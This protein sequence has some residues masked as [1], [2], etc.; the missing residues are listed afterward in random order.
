MVRGVGWL[1][2]CVG[3]LVW[4]VCLGWLVGWLVGSRVEGL[5]VGG[6]VDCRVVINYF[7]PVFLAYYL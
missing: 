7:L 3:W 4:L 5:R 2:G 1:V 6:L